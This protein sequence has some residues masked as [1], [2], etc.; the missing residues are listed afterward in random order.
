MAISNVK[1]TFQSDIQKV[2]RTIT[3]L[4]NYEWRSD[5][6]RIEILDEKKF[7]E[8]TKEG[9]STTFIITIIEPYKRWEFDMENDNIKGHWIGIFTQK[10]EQ[11]EVDFIEDVVA[12]K[13]L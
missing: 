6:S 10:G 12:K 3:D 13:C 11:T 4:K 5:L 1:V 7:V 2:W 8:Y 9:Y